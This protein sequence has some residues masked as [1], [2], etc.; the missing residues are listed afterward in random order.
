MW[1]PEPIQGCFERWMDS[2]KSRDLGNLFTHL[3]DSHAPEVKGGLHEGLSHL[4][5]LP[6]EPP[7]LTSK[8]YTP[9]S[10]KGRKACFL[11]PPK[12]STIA[13][14]SPSLQLNASCLLLVLHL[15][16]FD[17]SH[18]RVSNLVGLLVSCG[19][20]CQSLSLSLFLYHFPSRS[21]S[22]KFVNPLHRRSRSS[23]VSSASTQFLRASRIQ[24]TCSPAA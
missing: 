20:L 11:V 12:K 10:P 14:A 16:S 6:P 17:V 23:K 22:R 4:S 9:H 5:Q 3:Q 24:R 15:L 13:L 1:H 19:D 18:L 8:N 7:R 21:C 2:K